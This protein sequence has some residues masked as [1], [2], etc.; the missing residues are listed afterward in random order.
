MYMVVPIAL[1][2]MRHSHAETTRGFKLPF[3]HLICGLLFVV[4]AVFFIFIGAKD[5]LYLTLT[6]TALMGIFLALN[7][8]GNEGYSFGEIFK[9]SV[10]FV[11]FL[12]VLTALILLGPDS[13][14]GSNY[15]GY[16]VFYGLYVVASTYAFYYFTNKNFV[17]KCQVIR[18][19]DNVEIAD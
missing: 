6:M 4:Q 1:I 5:M 9:I 2:A 16:N 19:H 3:A 17:A 11:I 7:A 14:G 12:W 10:P 8:R 15:L 13:Y 18:N